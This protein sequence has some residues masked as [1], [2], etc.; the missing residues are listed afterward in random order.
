M[1][2]KIYRLRYLPLFE[3][4]LVSTVDYIARVLKNRGA[5]LRLIDDV[6]KVRRLLHGARD[7]ER[8]LLS[9]VAMKK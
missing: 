5:A 7:T 2:N 4:N 3:Q 6:M 9:D 8:H 1:E